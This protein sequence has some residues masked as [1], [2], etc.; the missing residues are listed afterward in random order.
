MFLKPNS[1]IHDPFLLTFR[2]RFYFCAQSCYLLSICKLQLLVSSDTH[3]DYLT[4][5]ASPVR[6]LKAQNLATNARSHAES[7]VYCQPCQLIIG[8]G[9]PVL[10]CAFHN[11]F[12]G[13]NLQSRVHSY[14]TEPR[15]SFLHLTS[16]SSTELS[17]GRV[18]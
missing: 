16:I 10:S 11:P 7:F 1:E 12:L 15:R 3:S 18:V 4:K 13:N 9:I 14:S 8:P 2:T 6:K 5:S 17:K